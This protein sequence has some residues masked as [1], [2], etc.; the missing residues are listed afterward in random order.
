MLIAL[1]ELSTIAFTPSPVSIGDVHGS[2]GELM[3]E[4]MAVSR[5]VITS[6]SI[7]Y[8][9]LY[10]SKPDITFTEFV[11]AEGISHGGVK[12]YDQLL[13]SQIERP[14]VGQLFG[15]DPDSVITSYSIHYTKLY[16]QIN[17]YA[18][19]CYQDGIDGGPPPQLPAD[20]DD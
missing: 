7:H 16:D 5:F 17:W 12:L 19:K 15:K 2:I 8:T 10:D 3:L 18:G 4:V 1:L 9:K 20:Q 6:Y 11:S 13:F 14:I